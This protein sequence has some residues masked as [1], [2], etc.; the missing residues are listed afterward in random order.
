MRED[1][2][3]LPRRIGSARCGGLTGEVAHPRRLAGLDGEQGSDGPDGAARQVRALAD[4]GGNRRL[5]EIDRRS[6]KPLRSAQRIAEG[7]AWPCSGAATQPFGEESDVLA[8][9]AADDARELV[10]VP[11]QPCPLERLAVEGLL[12]VFEQQEEVEDLRVRVR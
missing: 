1:I 2:V 3:R 7:R 9:L 6:P 4:V 12:Q 10:E 8:L 11:R 5:L